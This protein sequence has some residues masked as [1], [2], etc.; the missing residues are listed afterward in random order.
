MKR[1]KVTTGIF[2]SRCFASRVGSLRARLH[3]IGIVRDSS[4]TL[5]CGHAYLLFARTSAWPMRNA[6]SQTLGP[7]R[8]HSSSSLR[9]RTWLADFAARLRS[10]PWG[11]MVP[12]TRREQSR[13]MRRLKEPKG[14]A[15]REGGWPIA[16]GLADRVR[17][18]RVG[19]PNHGSTPKRMRIRALLSI[20]LTAGWMLPASALACPSDVTDAGA[21]S[22]AVHSDSHEHADGPS[23]HGSG[24]HDPLAAQEARKG[25]SGAPLDTP[26]CCSDDTR[27][28]SAVASVLVAKPRP[29]SSPVSLASSHLG[30]LRPVDLPSGSRLRLRQPAPLAYA[31]TRRPLL[32]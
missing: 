31:Q 11:Y 2:R 14:L 21:H 15:D 13:W 10:T 18:R 20:A 30:V 23:D 4:K 17:G 16:K 1:R 3:I 6:R 24:G 8:R 9:S 5:C 12:R 29:K 26:A 22:H 25:G 28:P 7:P 19:R 32:I 27:T